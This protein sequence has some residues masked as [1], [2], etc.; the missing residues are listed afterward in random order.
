MFFFELWFDLCE[1]LRMDGCSRFLSY[2]VM[3]GEWMVVDELEVVVEFELELFVW[4]LVLYGFEYC[5]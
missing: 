3:W 4:L 5:F 1:Y 2:G